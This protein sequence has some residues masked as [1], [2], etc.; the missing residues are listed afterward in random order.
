[1]GGDGRPSALAA[2]SA[3]CPSGGGRCDRPSSRNARASA[4]P[5]D[6]RAG[7]T[8]RVGCHL[9]RGAVAP[10]RAGAGGLALPWRQRSQNASMPGA[11]WFRRSSRPGPDRRSSAPWRSSS[12]AGWSPPPCSHSSCCRSST[13][14]SAR[15]GSK[16]S[17]ATRVSNGKTPDKTDSKPYGGQ[18][19][20]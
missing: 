6:G 5:G 10:G 20:C 9:R 19:P 8:G 2:G 1:M 15:N 16:Q 18:R 17:R 7:S 4:A 11:A 12:S 14:V 13:D 3:R